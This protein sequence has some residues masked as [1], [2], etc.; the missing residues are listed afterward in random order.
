M[1]A[2][3][4]VEVTVPAPGPA[5]RFEI[6]NL[7]GRVIARTVNASDANR[8]GAIG[9]AQKNLGDCYSIDAQGSRVAHV[10]HF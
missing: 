10:A 3:A 7:T 5:V 2:F 8:V 9:H 6:T 4:A 1:I